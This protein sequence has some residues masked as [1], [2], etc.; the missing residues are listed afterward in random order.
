MGNIKNP[1]GRNQYTEKLPAGF[2]LDERP[3]TIKLEKKIRDALE[4][5]PPGDRSQFLR[6]VIAQAVSEAG[7]LE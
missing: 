6:K 1:L 4:K 7:L 5:I 3:I 2:K